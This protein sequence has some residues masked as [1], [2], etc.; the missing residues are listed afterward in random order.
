[1]ASRRPS[2]TPTLPTRHVAFASPPFSPSSSS[3]R[4][5]VP[6]AGAAVLPRGICGG[7]R[8]LPSPL[9]LAGF[10]ART[11]TAAA[12][13]ASSPAEGNGETDAAGIPRTL[14][15]GTMIVVWYLLNIYFN[16]YNKL[17]PCFLSLNLFVPTNHLLMVFLIRIE[18]SNLF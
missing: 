16:I 2:A 5:P 10:A 8:P 11:R 15:L 7:L 3:C 14:Q 12:A 6:G 4:W 9:L 13:A 17:V 1:V 18:S